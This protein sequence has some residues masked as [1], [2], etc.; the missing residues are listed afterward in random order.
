M[1]PTLKELL[2]EYNTEHGYDTDERTLYETL[3]ECF[4]TVWKD[5]NLDKHRWYSVQEQVVEMYGRFF[6][7]SVYIITGDNNA[8]DMGLEPFKLEDIKE[9]YQKEVTTI[10]YVY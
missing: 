8:D 10:I 6:M 4:K 3:K 5:P 7:Y 9:V 2:I 1:E